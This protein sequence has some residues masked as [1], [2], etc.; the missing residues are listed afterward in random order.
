MNK[1][2]EE[3]KKNSNK[4]CQPHYEFLTGNNSFSVFNENH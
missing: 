2:Q 4:F 1:K 3:N